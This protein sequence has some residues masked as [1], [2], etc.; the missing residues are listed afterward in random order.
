VGAGD[1]LHLTLFWQAVA[2]MDAD[3]TLTLQLQDQAG[4]VVV[5]REVKPTGGAHPPYS[6]QNGEIV[7][8][9]QNFLLPE[10]LVA[11]RYDLFVRIRDLHIEAPGVLL[12]SIR[13]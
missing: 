6:W 10:T 1:T 2:E 12:T 8:D 3:F 7:R 4:N 9:Q 13:I 11:C 5:S